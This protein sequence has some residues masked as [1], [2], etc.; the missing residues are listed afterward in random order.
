MRGLPFI[1]FSKIRVNPCLHNIPAPRMLELWLRHAVPK[2]QV[3]EYLR[4]ILP[5]QNNFKNH[6]SVYEHW[7]FVVDAAEKLIASGTAHLYGPSEGRPKVINPLGVALNGIQERLVLNGIYI[8]AFMKQFP[9]KYERLRDIVTFLKKGG[10]I[11]T[12][13]LES[14]YFHVLVHPKFKT[15]FGFQIGNA[16]LHFNGVCF[17]WTHACFIFSTVMQEVF[18]EVRARG[19]PVSSYIDDG[20]TA[21]VVQERC[22]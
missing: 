13:D 11:A 1:T 12:W 9:F 2:G 16:Y 14:G 10:F 21:D 3:E 19:I 22:L 20:L 17:E 5:H 7:N 4:G 8:N 6:R 15:Y 18:L